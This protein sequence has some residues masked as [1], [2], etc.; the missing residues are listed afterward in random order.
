[1]R[2]PA[3]HVESSELPEVCDLLERVLADPRIPCGGF[4]AEE[5]LIADLDKRDR[6]IV[7]GVPSI[8]LRL[9][10]CRRDDVTAPEA[11]PSKQSWA[12]S[13][14]HCQIT[15]CF[16][17]ARVRQVAGSIPELH[18]HVRRSTHVEY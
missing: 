9:S 12:L 8:A 11:F 13:R 15:V 7:H 16:R 5:P 14:A 4:R 17:D 2:A 10:A 3:V 18:A 6:F 1:M